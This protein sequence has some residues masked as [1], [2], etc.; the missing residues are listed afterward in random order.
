MNLEKKFFQTGSISCVQKARCVQKTAM[1]VI[2]PDTRLMLKEHCTGHLLKVARQIL[3]KITAVGERFLYKLSSAQLR[4]GALKENIGG[5]KQA[6][7][8][9]EN[10][11]RTISGKLVKIVWQ[12]GL[13]QCT[14]CGLAALHLF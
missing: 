3:L 12:Y 9:M 13:G 14:F 8:K 7:G 5:T 10:Y 2:Q 6:M 11:R 4:Q 1:S